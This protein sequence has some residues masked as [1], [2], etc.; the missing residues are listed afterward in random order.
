MAVRD[1]LDQPH[2]LEVADVPEVPEDRAHQR[3]MLRAKV[4]LGEGL[5]EQEG[6][7]ACLVE[8]RD[9]LFGIQGTADL[10]I[11]GNDGG[12]SEVVVR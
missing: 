7:F 4:L 1:V 5:R 10:K 2:F 8:Q 9:D 12:S 3:I 6:A 11:H